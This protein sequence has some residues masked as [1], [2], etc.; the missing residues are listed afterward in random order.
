MSITIQ[1]LGERYTSLIA[2]APHLAPR[3]PSTDRPLRFRHGDFAYLADGTAD[4]GQ[5]DVVFSGGPQ[6]IEASLLRNIPANHCLCNGGDCWAVRELWLA[7]RWFPTP[8]EAL[9]VFHE[10]ANR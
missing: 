7:A 3:C 4:G 10:E 1:Q 8:L 2:K 6:M 9:L 5:T